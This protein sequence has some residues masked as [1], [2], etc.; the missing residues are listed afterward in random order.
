MNKLNIVI[1]ED[2]KLAAAN[3]EKIIRKLEPDANVLAILNSVKQAIS[4]LSQHKA[5][6]I[7]MD[8]ELGDGQSFEIFQS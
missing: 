5:D 8:I 7:F 2:E 1:I 4:R 3:L 6:L